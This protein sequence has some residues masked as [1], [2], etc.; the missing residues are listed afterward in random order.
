M[1]PIYIL[2]T[3][4][5]YIGRK[6]RGKV[7]SMDSREDDDLSL[8]QGLQ[9]DENSSLLRTVQEENKSS[10]LQVVQ[11][12]GRRQSNLRVRFEDENSQYIKKRWQRAI[13]VASASVV[14]ILK[15]FETDD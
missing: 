9:E 10:L 15:Y 14:G 7:V 2:I 3:D 11:E 6:T 1:G 12:R 13:N 4:L 8:L 5:P